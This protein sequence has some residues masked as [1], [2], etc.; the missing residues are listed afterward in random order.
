MQ[1][2]KIHNIKIIR[3]LRHCAKLSQIIFFLIFIGVMRPTS[4]LY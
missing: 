2:T 3:A 1:C 4:W